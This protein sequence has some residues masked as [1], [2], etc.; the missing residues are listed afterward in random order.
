MADIFNATVWYGK[1][2]RMNGGRKNGFT[3]IELLVVISIIGTLA[4]VILAALS[5]ARERARIGVDI[6]FSGTNYH[7]LGATATVVYHLDGQGTAGFRDDSGNGLNLALAPLG[8]PGSP[9]SPGWAPGI[10]GDGLQFTPGNAPIL[11]TNS[12]NVGKSWTMSAWVDSLALAGNLPFLSMGD[13]YLQTVGTALGG[14]WLDSGGGTHNIVETTQRSTGKWYQVTFT[15]NEV[16][17]TTALYVDGKMV[18]APVTN[19]D[20]ENGSQGC[21]AKISVGSWCS[22]TVTFSGILDEIYVYPQALSEADVQNLYAEQVR[23]HDLA[24]NT[25]SSAAAVR[26]A[27]FGH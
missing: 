1:L 18:G 16:G 8:A 22:N 12:I 6:E 20:S 9:V 27:A 23:D 7:A 26:Q 19:I 11:S 14:V 4:S 15:H 13:M 24:H 10:I 21:L 5:S 17:G 2:Y 3:L 25:G